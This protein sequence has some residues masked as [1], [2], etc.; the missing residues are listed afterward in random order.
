MGERGGSD[1]DLLAT[2]PEQV[3][4]ATE[5]V[6]EVK[7]LDGVVEEVGKEALKA[8]AWRERRVAPAIIAAPVVV[9]APLPIFRCRRTTTKGAVPLP[10]IVT[11]VLVTEHEVGEPCTCADLPLPEWRDVV[12][13]G[14]GEHDG[15]DGEVLAAT[16]GACR[17][18]HYY[19][20]NKQIRKN[21]T[22][23]RAGDTKF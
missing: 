10:A 20:S 18:P 23:T 4:A 19:K 1:G 12:G 14:W 2:L 16:C 21:E 8:G 13:M 11:G 15:G 7:R 6:L 3:D 17:C 22:K 9:H 5:R